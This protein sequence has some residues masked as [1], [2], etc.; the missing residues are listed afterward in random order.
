METWMIVGL[1]IF[2]ILT[3]WYIHDRYVQREQQITQ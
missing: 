1:L 2:I 3:A